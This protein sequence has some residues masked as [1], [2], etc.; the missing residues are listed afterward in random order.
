MYNETQQRELPMLRIHDTDFYVDMAKLEFRQVDNQKNVI[1]FNNVQDNGDHTQVMYDPKTKNAFQGNW[2]DMSKREDLVLVKLPP[3]VDLDFNYL[4]SQLN[5]LSEQKYLERQMGKPKDL[6]V[7]L[8]RP[9]IR[10]SKG[11]GI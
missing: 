4:I 8:D 3:A 1:S 5:R 11:K 2:G 6:Q 10:Q 7:P 9:S